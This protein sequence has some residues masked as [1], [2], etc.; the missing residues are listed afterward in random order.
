MVNEKEDEI[1]YNNKKLYI[2]CKTKEW[3]RLKW[4]NLHLFINV[5]CAKQ[6]NKYDNTH[7]QRTVKYVHTKC[8]FPTDSSKVPEINAVQWLNG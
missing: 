4:K 2:E 1:K 3:N 8:T 5:E 7:T 6:L